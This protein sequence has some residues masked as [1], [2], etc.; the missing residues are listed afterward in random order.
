MPMLLK[1]LL[2][3]Q[4]TLGYYPT[5]DLI[6][7]V[8]RRKIR[9]LELTFPAKQLQAARKHMSSKTEYQL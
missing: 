1:W 7:S 5:I 8:Q 2:S 3:L 9:L 4:H 6:Y